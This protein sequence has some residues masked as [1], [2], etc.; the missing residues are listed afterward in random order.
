MTATAAFGSYGEDLSTQQSGRP[1]RLQLAWSL[2]RRAVTVHMA[3]HLLDTALT[4]MGVDRDC[5]DDL[6]LALTEACANAIRHGRGAPEY[7][8]T[9]TT[10]DDVC[11][12]EVVDGGLGLDPQRLVETGIGD[13]LS[14][15]T[16]EHGRGLRLIRACVDA[17]ELR[18][19]QPHGLAI[20][21]TKKLTWDA[22]G[23]A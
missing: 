2:P 4:V 23:S 10:S 11:A 8:V 14:Q 3:R 21:M 5:R 18:P 6:A 7:R 15:V 1:S 22:G 12:V 13:G 19:V 16:T 17:L 20:R 9:V